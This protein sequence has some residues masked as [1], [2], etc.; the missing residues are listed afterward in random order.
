MPGKLMTRN[1]ALIF[2]FKII[3]HPLTR[4][5]GCFFFATETLLTLPRGIFRVP[6]CALIYNST[7]VAAVAKVPVVT[8]NTYSLWTEI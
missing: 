6:I 5:S 7:A 3:L 2:F 4:R 8:I 1:P